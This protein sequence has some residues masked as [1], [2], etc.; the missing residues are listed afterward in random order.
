MAYP[1]VS[2][3]MSF[4]TLNWHNKLSPR[5]QDTYAI[6]NPPK[7]DINLIEKVNPDNNIEVAKRNYLNRSLLLHKPIL[8]LTSCMIPHASIS[9]EIIVFSRVLVFSKRSFIFFETTSDVNKLE[10]SVSISVCICLLT[11]SMSVNVST[12][13]FSYFGLS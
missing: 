4:R 6:G 7:D 10:M 13:G 2:F 5:I 1:I 3:V 11:T 9:S 8:M 12:F